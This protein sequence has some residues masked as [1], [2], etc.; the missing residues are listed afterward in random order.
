MATDTVQTSELDSFQRY[1]DERC[2]GSLNGHSLSEA[3][4]KYRHYEKQLAALRERLRLSEESA[5]RDGT[6]L[7]TDE[8]VEARYRKLDAELAEEGITD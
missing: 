2:G 5:K 6:L 8:V 3:I 4:E 7:M 1:I